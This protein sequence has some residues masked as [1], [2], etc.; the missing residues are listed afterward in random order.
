MCKIYLLAKLTV[1]TN[2]LTLVLGDLTIVNQSTVIPPGV[3]E[4]C[5][6]LL[7]VDDEIVEDNEAFTIIVETDDPSGM[8]NGN[9]SIVIS[10]N[11]GKTIHQLKR[12]TLLFSQIIIIINIISGVVIRANESV[13][14]IEGGMK[15]SCVSADSAKSWE[16]E[17]PISITVTP[18]SSTNGTYVYV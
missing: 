4:A 16:R 18:N 6:L 13:F 17:I 12:M 1:H 11:D 2:F 10:D 14:L 5:V 8:V 15:G 7:A 3:S 9:A